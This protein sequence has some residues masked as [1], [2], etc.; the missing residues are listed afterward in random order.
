M[1][2]SFRYSRKISWRWLW[3]FSPVLS[4]FLF[5]YLLDSVFLFGRDNE[6]SD[7][8]PIYACCG[9]S[10]ASVFLLFSLSLILLRG[11]SSSLQRSKKQKVVLLY[12]ADD[13]GR[14]ELD[15]TKKVIV[16]VE[17]HR[18]VSHARSFAS[19]KVRCMQRTQ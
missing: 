10:F 14:V 15:S 4:F 1:P 8:T 19:W 13:L 9:A 3:I 17:L 6:V 18:P 11:Y 7:N 5:C 2:A 16:A 12:L